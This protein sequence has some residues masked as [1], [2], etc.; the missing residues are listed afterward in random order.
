MN[1]LDVQAGPTNL[2]PNDTRLFRLLGVLGTRDRTEGMAFG[3]RLPGKININMIPDDNP[4]L[5]QRTSVIFNA[6]ADPQGGNFFNA[7][8]VNTV[9]DA[10]SRQRTVNGIPGPG[11]R[12]ISSLIATTLPGDTQY[13]PQSGFNGSSLRDGNTPGTELID[14]PAGNSTPTHPYIQ[15]ELLRK[16]YTNLT[17]RSNTFAV[18][19]TVGMFDVRGTPQDWIGR[20][21]PLGGEVNVELRHRFFSIVDRTNLSMMDPLVTGNPADARKQGSR[22]IYVPFEPVA[23]VPPP[24]PT[25]PQPPNVAPAGSNLVQTTMF[26]TINGAQITI[27]DKTAQNGVTE[28]FVIQAG[29]VLY[30][31][32]GNAMERMQVVQVQQIS[33]VQAQVTMKPLIG[34]TT[35]SNHYRGAALST[36]IAGNPGPQNYPLNY[37]SAPYSNTVI[38]YQQILK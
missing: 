13:P 8:Q 2:G 36:A 11:D 18:F 38:A 20:P 3:G 5:P 4:N 29:S 31:D 19:V 12:P 32:V 23:V 33:A 21:P 34:A 37:F 1:P 15:G 17:T 26:G 25:S 24:A 6:L 16:I 9:W 10:L 7:N 14:S 30:L 27:E 35:Q 22:P 28:T